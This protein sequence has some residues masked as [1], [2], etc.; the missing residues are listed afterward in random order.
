MR[1]LR[2]R[3]AARLLLTR[4]A[5]V[6]KVL[7]NF[8]VA[9]V[10]GKM[11]LSRITGVDE[12]CWRGNVVKSDGWSK[13]CEGQHVLYNFVVL[14]SQKGNIQ[15]LSVFV[16]HTRK[17]ALFDG[18]ACTPVH[19]IGKITFLGSRQSRIKLKLRK[20]TAMRNG[21]RISFTVFI[22]ICEQSPWQKFLLICACFAS[23]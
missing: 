15:A 4:S 18:Y 13:Q 12:G 20:Q 9:V 22:R 10:V 8:M 3:G 5:V 14:A 21:A 6:T 2:V 1:S 19:E 16:P 23:I 7:R 11:S 17:S